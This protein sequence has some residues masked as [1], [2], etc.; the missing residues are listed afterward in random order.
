MLADFNDHP[1]PEP[2]S[3]IFLDV[4]HFKNINDTYLHLTGD[5]VLIGLAKLLQSEMYSSETIGRYGGEEFI[6]V[7]P[8][9]D[10][11]Q[12]IAKA[13]RLR[14]AICNATLCDVSK[15]KVTVS[16]GVTEIEPGDT[17]NEIFGR[18]DKALF[19]SKDNGRN[20]TTAL[21]KTEFLSGKAETPQ[22][23]PVPTYD[24]DYDGSFLA[25]VTSDMIVLNFGSF[26][27]EHNTR[28]MQTDQ[29]HAV[30]RLG[31]TFL[32]PFWGAKQA[33]QPVE[34]DITFGPPPKDV[35]L[36]QKQRASEPTS[37]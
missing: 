19:A 33:R 13:E 2:M 32:L 7:C 30:I 25:C 22:V 15:M 35:L 23:A 11:K 3:L 18:A 4:D 9:T 6:V 37:K 20:R 8:S 36:P 26:V 34:L 21:T 1:N 12:A 16:F 29:G 31:S 24:Y 10:L 14:L 27:R 17:P 5:Q 28:L